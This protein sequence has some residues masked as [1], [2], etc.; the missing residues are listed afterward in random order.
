MHGYI[1]LRQAAA[2]NMGGVLN[3]MEPQ[4]P[5]TEMDTVN[6]RPLR[7]IYRVLFDHF[8][9]SASY[10]SGAVH[11]RTQHP[12]RITP[13]VSLVPVRIAPSRRFAS[14]HDDLKILRVDPRGS[15]SSPIV[16]GPQIRQLVT[17]LLLRL[18]SD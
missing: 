17:K 1:E 6:G 18:F 2:S 7:R 8:P 10:G 14:Y 5:R 4:L 13:S 9:S 16:T 15:V 3:G 11:S 12:G